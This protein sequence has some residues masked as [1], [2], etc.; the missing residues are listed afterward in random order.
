[1]RPRLKLYTGEG[2]SV[3]CEEPM[4]GVR[5]GDV[6]QILADAGRLRRTWLDDFADDEIQVPA[7]LFEV[8]AACQYMRPGA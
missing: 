7:D 1:M 3:V 5:L 8:L 2:E 4:V 6:C